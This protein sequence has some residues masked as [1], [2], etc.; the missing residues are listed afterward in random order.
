MRLRSA[1]VLGLTAVTLVPAPGAVAAGAAAEGLLG[2]RICAVAPL[3][4]SGHG[5]DLSGCGGEAG[6]TGGVTE[7]VTGASGAGTDAG[8]RRMGAGRTGANPS[9]TKA[10]PAGSPATPHHLP[11]EAT[12]PRRVQA[13]TNATPAALGAPADPSADQQQPSCGD[14]GSADFPLDTGIH[15]G[16]YTYQPGGDSGEWYVD[17]TNT[18]GAAC[19]DIHPV[20]VLVDKKRSLQ[21]GQLRAEFQDAGTGTWHPVPFVRT[22]RDELI[23]VFAEELPGFTV[24]A[25]ST[26]PVKVRL[27]F[28][29]AAGANTVTA[30]TAVVQRKAD[31][32]EWV[33]ESGDYR[34]AIDPDLPTEGPVDAADEGNPRGAGDTGDAGNSADRDYAEGAGSPAEL[35]RSGPGPL[36]GLGSTAVACLLGGGALVVSSRR[37]CTPPKR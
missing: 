33:G 7:A 15:G 17:L 31:D 16:P 24:G 23:G 3:L 9:G 20:L 26:L 4:G 35:A 32:G 2:S 19:R 1:L 8:A 12:T 6:S 18:T 10:S 27:G 34:F 13:A 37:M 21:A 14:P 29:E 30:N 22:D 5:Q 25:G 36:L 28:T 11:Q